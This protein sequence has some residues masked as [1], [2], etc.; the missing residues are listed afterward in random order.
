MQVSNPFDGRKATIPARRNLHGEWHV[1]F[2]AEE[3]KR[4]EDGDYFT[5]D[6]CDAIRT[7]HAMVG[8]K[9]TPEQLERLRSFATAY[10]I[11]WKRALTDAWLA[12]LD[13]RMQ[14]G[15]LLRQVRNQLGP[16]W[17]EAFRFSHWQ[18]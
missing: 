4:H 11:N 10:G 8:M 15:H 7:A 18:D 1:K 12:G 13:E 14:D 5:N 16:R 17:L 6:E 2:Y 9:P 3:G